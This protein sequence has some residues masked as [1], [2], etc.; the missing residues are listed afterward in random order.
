M[1]TEKVSEQA[2]S[3]S[4]IAS[5]N[6]Q[7]VKLIF[8]RTAVW[9]HFGFEIVTVNG[10]Q[11]TERE[12]RVCRICYN[13]VSYKAGITSNMPADLKQKHAISLSN[14]SHNTVS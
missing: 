11:M 1:A 4:Y 13:D 8:H 3:I 10:K 14:S 2:A 9:K 12:K 5:K 7:Q 6:N